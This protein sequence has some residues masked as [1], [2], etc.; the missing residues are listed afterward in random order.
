[1]LCL[2]QQLIMENKSLQRKLERE[3]RDLRGSTN[4]LRLRERER[5]LLLLYIMGL[6]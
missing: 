3:T 2:E 5:L 6:Q 4:Y 1:M